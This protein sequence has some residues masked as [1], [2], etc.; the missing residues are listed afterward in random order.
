MSHEIISTDAL[1]NQIKTLIFSAREKVAR[2]I[3]T[4]QVLTCFEIGRLIVE[5]E[6]QGSIRA[7]YGK[8]ILPD[9]SERLNKEFGKGFSL[10]NLKLMR[11]FYLLKKFQF[12]QVVL[13]ELSNA[14]KS[15][16]LSDQLLSSD[17]KRVLFSARKSM[18]PL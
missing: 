14:E 13:G 7:G 15:Q 12:D 2:N 1:L 18:M 9:L 3:D 11:Q 16:T 17:P 8:Q 6:Q 5:H 10:T 4:I